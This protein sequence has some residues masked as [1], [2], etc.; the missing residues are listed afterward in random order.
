MRPFSYAGDIYD[1]QSTGVFKQTQLSVGLNTMIGRWVTLFSRYAHGNAHSDTDGLTTMPANPYN[2]AGE[3]GRSALDIHNMLFL[4]GSISAPWGLRIS[5]FFIAHSGM[6]FNIT[7]GTD[8][9]G[10]GQVASAARP[11]VAG[12]PGAD[13]IHTPY[14][15]LDSCSNGR[16][17]GIREERG[18]RA[19]LSR[20]EYASQ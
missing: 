2:F 3:W 14:G 12:G 6:P 4:G 10:T 16:S 18:H 13:I 15:Y 19:R 5:P 7:T 11:G 1:Y 8:I 17:G 9:Y 20:I